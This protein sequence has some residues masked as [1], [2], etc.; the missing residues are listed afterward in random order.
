MITDKIR[1]TIPKKINP[2]VR[3]YDINFIESLIYSEKLSLLMPNC[4]L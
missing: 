4:G 2:K 1:N 3:L